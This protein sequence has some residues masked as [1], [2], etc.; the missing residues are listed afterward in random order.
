MVYLFKKNSSYIATT[1]LYFVDVPLKGLSADQK[2]FKKLNINHTITSTFK[3][4]T[5]YKVHKTVVLK[6][7]DRSQMLFLYVL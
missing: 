2:D 4:W 7:H 5:K 3:K 1:Y 6:T